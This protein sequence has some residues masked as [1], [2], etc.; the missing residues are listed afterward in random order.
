M[1]IMNIMIVHTTMIMDMM[2]LAFLILWMITMT[3]MLADEQNCQ[4]SIG[5][6]MVFNTCVYK[7]S[8][9]GYM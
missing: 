9:L 7:L 2:L 8:S 4:I 5:K 3:I 1:L 6:R